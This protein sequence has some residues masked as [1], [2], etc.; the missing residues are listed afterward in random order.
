LIDDGDEVPVLGML[1]EVLLVHLT[2]RAR[3]LMALG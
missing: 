1:G 2:V 3:R